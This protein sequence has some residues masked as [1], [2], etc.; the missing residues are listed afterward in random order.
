MRA[1]EAQVDVLEFRLMAVAQ[2]VDDQVAALE[3][4][5]GEVAAVEAERAQT[6]EPA[7]EA[8]EVLLQAA[9]VA[10]A[11]TCGSGSAG[12]AGVDGATEASVTVVAS[13]RRAAPVDTD[14]RPSASTRIASSAPTRLRRSA[15]GLPLNRLALESPTSAFGA[16]AISV[17]SRSRTLMS[18]MRMAA[19]PCSSRS[20][21]V[22][23]TSIW[24]WLPMFSAIAAVSHGVMMSREIGPRDRRHHN[25]PPTSRH[26]VSVPADDDTGPAHPGRLGDR[27]CGA[28]P[29]A[30]GAR[31][32]AKQLLAASLGLPA[33]HVG[34]PRSGT[35]GRRPHAAAFCCRP[36]RT[37]FW[38]CPRRGECRVAPSA[39]RIFA[40]ALIGRCG[41]GHRR[42]LRLRTL[43]H[44]QARFHG[45][46][47]PR[48]RISSSQ[49]P[50]PTG[51]SPDPPR[52]TSYELPVKANRP[53]GE[54]TPEM[55]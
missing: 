44:V 28:E 32:D 53:G 23:P 19:R 41:A 2:V 16:L 3:A 49:P 8:R 31:I 38:C 55:R 20:S 14:T 5:L 34:R 26:T 36:R 12:A 54:S 52:G 42:A 27:K 10:A 4:D 7:E 39:G 18:R 45:C 15:R 46:R 24:N 17:P 22:P 13:G 48:A 1:G 29:P 6:V 11:R 37:E 51:P 21:T 43:M 50:C 47:E 30:R 33:G 35:S 9:L 40:A 25:A